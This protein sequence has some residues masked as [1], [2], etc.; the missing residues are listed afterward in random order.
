M[1]GE[2]GVKGTEAKPVEKVESKTPNFDI[3]SLM[4]EIMDEE[5]A[6]RAVQD[7]KIKDI[8]SN[9]LSPEQVK[10]AL[11]GVLK[12]QSKSLED[13]KSAHEKQ[14]LD[15][16]EQLNNISSGTKAP[17]KVEGEPFKAVKETSPEDAM[18]KLKEEDY[19][20][21]ALKHFGVLK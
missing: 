12:S 13:V 14:L 6:A 19:N 7:K 10:E 18:A 15:L 8:E 1:A 21:W 2:E 5:K 3:D 11:K 16:Q 17:A 20:L 9:S 4:T